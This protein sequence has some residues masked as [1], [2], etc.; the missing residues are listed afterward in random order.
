MDKAQKLAIALKNINA[1]ITKLALQ[2]KAEAN[3]TVGNP[4]EMLKL[5]GKV[6][7][8]SSVSEMM[9]EELKDISDAFG[10]GK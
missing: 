3:Y 2:Y 5:N 7:A 6:D 9:G 4:T 10:V 8:L 1:G